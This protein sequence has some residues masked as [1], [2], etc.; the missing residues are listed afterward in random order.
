MSAPRPAHRLPVVGVLAALLVFSPTSLAAQTPPTADQEPAQTTD[1]APQ[2]QE[3]PYDLAALVPNIAVALSTPDYPVTP[4]DTYTLNYATVEGNVTTQVVVDADY[5]INLGIFGTINAA[6]LTYVEARSAIERRVASA[7]PRSAPSVALTAVGSF[8]VLV[9]GAVRQAERVGVWGLT[10]LSQLLTGRLEPYSSQRR[11]TI[12]SIDGTSQTYDLLRAQLFGEVDQDPRLEPGDTV[13]VVRAERTVRLEGEVYRPGTYELL[14]TEDLERLVRE[15]GRGT[16]PSADRSRVEIRSQYGEG[17]QW[18]DLD[19]PAA[20]V[21]LENGDTVTVSNIARRALAVYVEGGV[22]EVGAASYGVVEV[23][24]TEG[25]TAFEA[26]LAVREDLSPYADLTSVVIEPF[27]SSAETTPG[28]IDFAA[29]LEDYDPSLDVDLGPFDR[30]VVSAVQPQVL[31]SGAVNNPG[32]Q[33]V[34]PN[35]RANYYI[36]QAGGFDPERNAR[37]RF[38]VYSSG[39]RPKDPTAVIEPG[40]SIRA[41]TNSFLY[42]F[43]RFFPILASTLSFASAVI[44]F[45]SLVSN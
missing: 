8:R 37:D 31:V 36:R 4:G 20:A 19:S 44:S 26:L 35:Q 39:G 34:A 11:I 5:T 23:P 14:G 41:H 22:G 40:D 33:P 7:F 13:T 28:R 38:T 30:I 2:Q 15:F 6:G 43:N 32:L 42:A 1:Q 10:R 25:M 29:L 3:S 21:A 45:I 24:Y 9:R 18:I 16:M 12:E 27:R 17:V